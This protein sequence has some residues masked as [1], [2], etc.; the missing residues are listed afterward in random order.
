MNE[1]YALVEK[2]QD[3]IDNECD[4]TRINVEVEV[5][6]QKTS[7]LLSRLNDIEM[8]KPDKTIL[9]SNF[10]PTTEGAASGLNNAQM[11]EVMETLRKNKLEIGMANQ[12]CEGRG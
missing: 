5:L 7:D 9:S 3:K 4:N 2:L 11:A 12:A 6:Q 8:N 10:A 1:L